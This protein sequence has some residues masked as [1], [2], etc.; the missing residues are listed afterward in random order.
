MVKTLH[1]HSRSHMSCGMAKKK[2]KK[3]KLKK[4]SLG[5]ERFLM[6]LLK[7]LKPNLSLDFSFFLL[8]FFSLQFVSLSLSGPRQ[9]MFI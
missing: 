5:M 7:C 8:F 1:I 4:L 6:Q 9:G 2:K 3:K